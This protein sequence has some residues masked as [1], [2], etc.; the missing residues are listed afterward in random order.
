MAP[1]E[2]DIDVR[3][4]FVLLLVVLSACSSS[5]APPAA[6]DAATPAVAAVPT[7]PTCPECPGVSCPAFEEP[8][9]CPICPA[10]PACEK[11]D[12]ICTTGA[13]MIAGEARFAV[14]TLLHRNGSW[15]E[16]AGIS[17]L[18]PMELTTEP[19]AEYGRIGDPVIARLHANPTFV[20]RIQIG[21]FMY[22]QQG[23]TISRFQEG[24]LEG[25][26]SGVILAGCS[27]LP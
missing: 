24:T 23:R 11:P 9:P 3:T 14:R 19:D 25:G 1:K 27:L 22:E 18:G 15:H 5:K 20:G 6:E 26:G 10:C 12:A 16:V 21:E 8:T 13:V 4:I 7:C 17:Q 2:G